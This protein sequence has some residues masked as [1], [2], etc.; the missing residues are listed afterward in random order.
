MNRRTVLLAGIALIPGAGRSAE[1]CDPSA[2]EGFFG[3]LRRR[4]C[5]ERYID[6]QDRELDRLRWHHRDAVERRRRL[7]GEVAE[8]RRRLDAAQAA[9]RALGARIAALGDETA[10]LARRLRA[11]ATLK[12]EMLETLQR[13]AEEAA[14]AERLAERVQRDP[15][16]APATRGAARRVQEQG[17]SLRRAI[18]EAYDITVGVLLPDPGD[19]V[20]VA[21]FLGQLI[22]RLG[23]ARRRVFEGLGYLYGA[24]NELLERWHWFD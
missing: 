18:E 17:W 10:S 8:A 4:N 16:A 9:S 22:S 19:P 23:S 2:I 14:R 5:A 6:G 21:L 7:E 3:W 11:A 24:V 1:P 13:F 20:S 15:A 12:A